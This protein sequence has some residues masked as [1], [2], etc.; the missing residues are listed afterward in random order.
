[1]FKGFICLFIS[2]NLLNAQDITSLGGDFSSNIPGQN[3]IAVAPDIIKGERRLLQLNGFGPFHG[4]NFDKST[5]LGPKLINE[6]CG[7]CHIRNGKGLVDGRKK[8]STVGFA[9]TSQGSTMVV[10]VSLKGLNPDGSPRDVPGIGEQLLDKTLDDINNTNIKLTWRS[11]LGKYPDKTKFSL[12]AP[13]LKFKINN[14]NPRKDIVTSLR[15]TPTVIGVGLLEAVSDQ[16]IEN[17]ADPLD[18][19][20]DGVTGHPNY[21]PD[22]KNGGK[23]VGRFGF[24]ASH[25]T[26][27]QQ[28]AAAFIHDMGLTN[29]LFKSADGTYEVPD[30]E[31]NL[32]TYY[33]KLG[34]VP[35]ARNQNDPRVIK[36]KELF[37]TIGC[38]S[39][40]RMTL[41]TGNHEDPELSNQ[42]IH[43]FTDLLL[44]NMGEGL[45]D[46]RAEFS[47]T[48]SHWKTTPL[49]GL[50][51]ASDLLN[52]DGKT[53][54]L[55][56]GRA[57][58]I[59][60]A[61]LWHGG[62]AQN[63]KKS[64]M[65]L[66]KIDRLDLIEFLKSL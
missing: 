39:C 15:M 49:W 50:G 7:G 47:A 55:H 64:F 25:P 17:L 22:L 61:I 13:I 59:E 5:G 34:G 60:E 14:K 27:E 4:K 36:G 23:K 65:N 35:F 41:K 18:S 33:Q 3:A 63:S 2:I 1:M 37:Q 11:I 16:T 42:E 56:D 43:P 9:N 45:A 30:S 58:T 57:R 8:S 53:T 21:I 26:V 20:K 66:K 52:P 24:R 10:K 62:E 38:N 19:N 32:V 46:K 28:T 48:G 54:F 40:H 29:Y 12:R 44:H 51:F 6:A 31:L